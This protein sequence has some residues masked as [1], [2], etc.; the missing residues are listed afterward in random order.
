MKEGRTNQSNMQ[1]SRNEINQTRVSHF[2]Y[3]MMAYE[4]E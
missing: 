3:M 2:E 4:K 1:S